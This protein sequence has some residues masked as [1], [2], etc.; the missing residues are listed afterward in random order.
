MYRKAG[1]SANEANEARIPGA[2]GTGIGESH[3]AAT[4]TALYG[5]VLLMAAIAYWIL[6]RPLIQPRS[7]FQNM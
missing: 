2:P 3:F 5:V 1:E 6:Q 7:A 4:P